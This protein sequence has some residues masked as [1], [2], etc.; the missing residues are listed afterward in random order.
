MF[1]EVENAVISDRLPSEEPPAKKLRQEE[2][3][4][5]Q[6]SFPSSSSALPVEMITG[7]VLTPVSS[8]KKNQ[9]SLLDARLLLET[10]RGK[11]FSAAISV[12]DFNSPDSTFTPVL[13]DR[14]GTWS[15]FLNLTEPFLSSPLSEEENRSPPPPLVT[16]SDVM[17]PSTLN[18]HPD[19]SSTSHTSQSQ[20]GQRL[21]QW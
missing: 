16:L 11:Y 6:L 10:E 12:A 14:P 18:S 8:P 1:H 15:S 9:T 3:T 4:R 5:Q 2:A 17:Q 21:M 20:W 7:E 13:P 19:S